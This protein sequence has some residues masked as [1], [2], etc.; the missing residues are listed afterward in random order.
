MFD[1]E[2]AVQNWRQ[3][4]EANRTVA[5]NALDELEDHIREEFAA[6][7]RTGKSEAD[8]WTAAIARLGDPAALRREFAKVDRLPALDRWTFAVLL[9]TAAA[10]FGVAVI[11]IAVMRPQ[12]IRNEP[13][14][15]IHVATI[16]LGY[17]SGL[18]AALIAGYATMRSYF[19][20]A[21][22]PAL[23]DT[24]LRLVR[25]AS[26]A[27]TVLTLIGF[28]LGAVWANNEWGRPFN[29]DPREIGG[30]VVAASFLT[31]AV[32]TGRR[33]IPARISLAITIAA[34]TT[35]LAAWFGIAAHANNYPPLLTFITVFGLVLTLGLAALSLRTHSNSATH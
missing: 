10:L 23:T 30:L 17:T 18:F 2:S 25:I 1:L 24:A 20:L 15:S 8:A 19:S 7:V 22:I 26:V 31:A 21:L 5:R 9:T 11:G 35:V 3:Q 14:F 13:V 12:A 27:A 32:T 6:L 4:M 34:A 29:M 16:T 33:A 28:V